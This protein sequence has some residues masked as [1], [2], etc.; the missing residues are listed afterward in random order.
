MQYFGR[1]GELPVGSFR[2][3]L[4]DVVGGEAHMIGIHSSTGERAGKRLEE[5][6]VLV[7]HLRDGKVAECWEHYEDSRPVD[8]FFGS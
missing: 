8:D 1:I 7:I 2:A 3:E 6:T 5:H 4:H